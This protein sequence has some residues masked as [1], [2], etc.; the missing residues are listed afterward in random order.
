MPL[1]TQP[2]QDL[3]AG[4]FFIIADQTGLHAH[5]YRLNADGSA[6]RYVEGQDGEPVAGGTIRF[7]AREKII[8]V[9]FAG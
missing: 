2:L 7:S 5:L 3:V 6:T 9:E 8:P 1:T 4:Q